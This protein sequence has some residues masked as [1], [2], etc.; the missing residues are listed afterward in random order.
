V[1]YVTIPDAL[2]LAG[3][4]HHIS[5]GAV[6]GAN[7]TSFRFIERLLHATSANIDTV[8]L[9]PRLSAPTVTSLG[10]T[11]SLRL[12]ARL[13]LQSEYNTAASAQFSQADNSV[14]VSVTATYTGGAAGTWTIDMP[15]LASAG[16][17][18]TW[19][20]RAGVAVNWGVSAIGGNVLPFI[21][22]PPVDALIT[23]AAAFSGSP[24]VFAR[25]ARSR[26]VALWP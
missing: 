17:D 7:A 12:R 1:P 6:S 20:M 16:Y 9:G 5:I 14:D 25:L 24:A 11:P 2:I 26:R 8:T 21:G 3:D 23:G 18:A 13:P 15:D 10:T 4:Y 19:G 22:A